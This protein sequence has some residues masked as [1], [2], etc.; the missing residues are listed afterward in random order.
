MSI[1]AA[2]ALTPALRG[3]Y[4]SKG[5]SSFSRNA[6]RLTRPGATVNTSS[7]A[8]TRPNAPAFRAYSTEGGASKGSGAT[9]W[10]LLAAALAAGGGYYVYANPGEAGTIL[11]EGKQSVKAATGFTPK[12]ADYQTVYNKIAE[13]LDEAG[14][15]DG[16]WRPVV[17]CT[18]ADA[19]LRRLLWTRA[20][21]SR[22]AREWNL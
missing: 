22:L 5:F 15:Y 11:K 14:E 18:R 9:I 1:R 2:F 12:L 7:R 10:L 17:D 16:M 6:S 13:L 21:S 8:F 4:G 20:R 3:A 19:N